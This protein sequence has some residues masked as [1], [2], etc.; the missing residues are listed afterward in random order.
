M[1]AKVFVGALGVI[2]VDASGCENRT[3]Y[4]TTQALD[5]AVDSKGHVWFT[6]N[7][8][9]K[10]WMCPSNG[11]NVECSTMG[12]GWNGPDG[13]AVYTGVGHG[14]TV[15]YV[16]EGHDI[17][18]K[19]KQCMYVPEMPQGDFSCSDFGNGWA[20]PRGLAVDT[21][22]NVFITDAHG[23][24]KCTPSAV[25]TLVGDSDQL[26]YSPHHAAPDSQG[27][28]YV[29]G[30][31]KDSWISNYV[32]KCPSTGTCSDFSGDWIKGGGYDNPIAVAR[33]DI[34]ICNLDSQILK[35]CSIDNVC[36]D[37]GAFNCH[38][39]MVIDDDSVF[40]TAD[41]YGLTRYCLSSS[42]KDI[43]I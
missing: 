17:A 30:G 31:D 23:V 6:D 16:S 4:H 33:D 18:P 26:P 32:K 43:Q 14:A 42:M 1:A 28:V 2:S 7:S 24:F 29:T 25:C 34:Y 22:G 41:Q 35:R 39:N 21:E 12:M 15:I 20:S 36:E 8:E 9:N 27:N 38:G 11:E 37:V 13:I 10:V 19:V 40:F 3:F 5:L